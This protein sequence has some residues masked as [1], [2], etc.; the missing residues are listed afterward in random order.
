[1]LSLR[2]LSRVRGTGTAM[3]THCCSRLPT[4]PSAPSVRRR[5]ITAFARLLVRRDTGGKGAAAQ[6]A[7]LAEHELR[8]R[9]SH[10]DEWVIVGW[11][12][13]HWLCLLTTATS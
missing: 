6:R 13:A 1:M 12:C 7:V 9:R 3:V 5:T 8:K 11:W 2:V 4:Y 10:A